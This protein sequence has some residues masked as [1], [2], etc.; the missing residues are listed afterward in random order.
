MLVFTS[1]VTFQYLDLEYTFSQKVISCI[2]YLPWVLQQDMWISWLCQNHLL[3][4]ELSCCWICLQYW[5]QCHH[6]L[7]ARYLPTTNNTYI[8]CVLNFENIWVLHTLGLS[9]NSG[10]ICG[11]WNGIWCQLTWFSQSLDTVPSQ[12]YCRKLKWFYSNLV[13]HCSKP[14]NEL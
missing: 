7:L 4:L 5:H 10:P 9:H 1:T 6:C 8:D 3:W 2:K 13:L 11:P 12:T 14:W